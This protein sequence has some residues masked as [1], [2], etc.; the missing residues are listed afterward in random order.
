MDVAALAEAGVWIGRQ[1]DVTV[2]GQLGRA[3]MFPPA[4]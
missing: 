4:A 1:L 3:G 2:P